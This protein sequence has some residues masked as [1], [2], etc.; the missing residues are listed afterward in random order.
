MGLWHT[1]HVYI[2][3]HIV[4]CGQMGEDGI[5]TWQFGL[6][7]NGR[8]GRP[9]STHTKTGTDLFI[10]YMIYE[11]S[12]FHMSNSTTIRD[13]IYNERQFLHRFI[14]PAM[15]LHTIYILSWNFDVF[16]AGNVVDVIEIYPCVIQLIFHSLS[17][18]ICGKLSPQDKLGSRSN[19]CYL[20]CIMTWTIFLYYK[21]YYTS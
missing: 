17:L 1:R 6:P 8:L 20:D 14:Y 13:N 9:R 16:C 3:C 11:S 4:K 10:F 21:L 7:L 12:M 18:D 5:P 2:S 15:I 19:M